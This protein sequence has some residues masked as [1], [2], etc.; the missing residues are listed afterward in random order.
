MRK[1]H[2]VAPP[3]HRFDHDDERF[4]LLFLADV[5]KMLSPHDAG[6]FRKALVAYKYAPDAVDTFVQTTVGLLKSQI[7]LLRMF[8]HFLNPADAVKLR[9]AVPDA[10][11]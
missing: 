5:K 2:M 4:A 3:A 10:F 11:A 6:M 1:P 7:V 9:D 8:E